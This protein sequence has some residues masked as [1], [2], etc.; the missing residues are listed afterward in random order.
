MEVSIV[1]GVFLIIIIVVII[2]IFKPTDAFVDKDEASASPP[3]KKESEKKKVSEKS[4]EE[5]I[6]NSLQKIEKHL[7]TI[8]IGVFMILFY[9]LLFQ[10]FIK[11]LFQ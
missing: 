1:L 3:T 6:L 2:V 10:N 5:R 9:A 7:F 8:K 4:N 11:D